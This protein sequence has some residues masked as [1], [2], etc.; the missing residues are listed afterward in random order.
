MQLQEAIKKRRSVRKFSTKKPDWKKIIKAIDS[1][2][3]NPMAGNYQTVK[4][5]II[6]DKEKIKKLQSACQQDF[7]G[8]V[9]YIVAVVS[10]YEYLKKMYSEFAEIYER[11]QA[12]AVIQTFLLNIVELGMATCWVGWFDELEIKSALSVPDNCKVE[13]IFPI[14]FET[15][16]PKT[17]AKKAELENILFFNKYGNKYMKTRSKVSVDGA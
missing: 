2:R 1:T 12:G 7:V 4:F 13:A 9:E 8:Q 5:I 14:G 3:W 17:R 11:Q 6:D 10:D 15:K 16:I